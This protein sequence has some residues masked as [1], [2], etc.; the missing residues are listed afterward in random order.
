MS[1]LVRLE[2]WKSGESHPT[3]TTKTVSAG[4]KGV[5]VVSVGY[6]LA[7]IGKINV[8]KEA[9]NTPPEKLPP[10]PAPAPDLDPDRACWPHSVA[11]NR[12]EIERMVHRL[13][14]FDGRGLTVPE[15]ERLADK[16]VLRD[17][18]EGDR[19]SCAECHRL[20]GWSPKTWRC[21]GPSGQGNTL[22]GAMLS[23]LWLSELHRCPGFTAH[24]GKLPAPV[25][26]V[27]KPA[28]PR[29]PSPPAAAQID[30]ELDRASQR[31]HWSCVHCIAAGQGRGQRCVPGLT[32]HLMADGGTLPMP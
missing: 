9:A 5:S 6:V 17:R 30:R 13:A 1:W 25:G 8:S 23:V 20:D 28:K 31:H 18:E 4:E 27:A 2:K 15:A 26:A 22:A 7:D 12:A 21:C 24:T 32:L 16:L 19:T 29:K 3:E 14:L 10:A 11:M